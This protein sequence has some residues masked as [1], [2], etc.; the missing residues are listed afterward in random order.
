M[1][2]LNRKPVG[3]ESDLIR[4]EEAGHEEMSVSASL[5]RDK[6]DHQSEQ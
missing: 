5:P 6:P 3:I 2:G 4:A 1:L